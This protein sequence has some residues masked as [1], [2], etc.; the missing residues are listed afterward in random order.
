VLCD[1]PLQTAFLL[2]VAPLHRRYYTSF[3][4]DRIFKTL[5]IGIQKM[6][7]MT[8]GG[9]TFVRDS[10]YIKDHF[11][12]SG[13]NLFS[14]SGDKILNLYSKRHFC[15]VTSASNLIFA[16]GRCRQIAGTACTHN[17]W[18]HTWYISVF[19]RSSRDKLSSW[20]FLAGT[21][22]LSRGISE[23]RRKN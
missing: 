18:H 11:G 2:D 13:R 9:N 19:Y 6:A 15:S 20:T 21:H 1:F 23:F 14:Q 16:C 7:V 10:I 12:K 8:S 3:A 5:K 17:V 22:V 4:A